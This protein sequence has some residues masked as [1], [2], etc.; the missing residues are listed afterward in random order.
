MLETV[1]TNR[2]TSKLFGNQNSDCFT[3]AVLSLLT[4]HSLL[5]G[6][7]TNIAENEDTDPMLEGMFEWKR[8]TS[9]IHT[10]SAQRSKLA[11][12]AVTKI[13]GEIWTK[14]CPPIWEIV[15]R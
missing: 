14:F 1:Q 5:K 7:V 3:T 8:K 4:A 12:Q 13:D 6:L 9:K 2:T 11:R 15:L 10:G